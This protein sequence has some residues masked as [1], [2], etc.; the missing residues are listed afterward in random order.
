M[1]YVD[2]KFSA[3]DFKFF[4]FPVNKGAI[5]KSSPSANAPNPVVRIFIKSRLARFWDL[6]GFAILRG[7]FRGENGCSRRIYCLRHYEK[8][9]EITI[10]EANPLQIH[11]STAA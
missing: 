1:K 7:Y 3:T 4:E 11:R 5:R 6:L 10:I 8:N 9:S 2:D